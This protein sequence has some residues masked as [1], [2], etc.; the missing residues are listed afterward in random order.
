MTADF[1][2]LEKI[3]SD[4]VLIKEKQ[5]KLLT[6]NELIKKALKIVPD[7]VTTITD[8]DT[9]INSYEEFARDEL[10]LEQLTI[11][12]HKSVIRNFM[13]HS[14][15]MINKQ[16]VKGYLDSNSSLSCKSNQVKAL[17]RY[18]RDYLRLGN[19]INEFVFA[20][21]KVK[22]KKENPTNKQLV[23]FYDVLPT[24]QIQIVF[25]VMLNSGLRENEVLS[26]KYSD[27]NNETNMIDASNIHKGKTKFSWIS[28]MTNQ[29]SELL[30]NYFLTDEFEFEEGNEDNTRLFNISS[31][32]LQ[33]AFKNASESIGMSIIPRLLRTVFAER[34]REAGID[35]EYI[36]AFCGRIPQ[37]VLE[38]H[39]TD[40]S[41]K[42]LRKQYDKLEPI[43]TLSFDHDYA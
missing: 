42:A 11:N 39:Y 10:K 35:K 17:R 20:K 2:K 33:N 3:V 4:L 38:K 22:L 15:G 26:L 18:I 9:N 8:F 41:P 25:L 19:W 16:T 7:K 30:Q 21:P 36:D 5:D 31:R 40:Y 43:L 1:E 34:C 37:G 27:F 24:Y 14:K 12:N 13:N 28:F 29:T 23:Q 32:S 6:D